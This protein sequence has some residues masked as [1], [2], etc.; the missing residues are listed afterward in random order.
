VFGVY[1]LVVYLLHHENKIVNLVSTV[2]ES[3][4]NKKM[5]MHIRTL[6]TLYFTFEITHCTHVK[7]AEKTLISVLYYTF[8]IAV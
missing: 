3:S 1:N 5:I 8:T 2:I 7:I 6:D 4:V